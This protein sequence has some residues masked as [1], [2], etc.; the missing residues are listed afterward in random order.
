MELSSNL[1]NTFTRLINTLT[2][3]DKAFLIACS[4]KILFGENC[5][6]RVDS[7]WKYVLVNDKQV[8]IG[9]VKI[10]QYNE[11]ER[12]I[13]EI[14]HQNEVLKTKNTELK[15]AL[16]VNK[17]K[18][19]RKLGKL[20]EQ[21]NMIEKVMIN[22]SQMKKFGPDVSTEN[23]AMKN[24][25]WIDDNDE[26]IKELTKIYKLISSSKNIYEKYNQ[27]KLL[28]LYD[29]LYEQKFGKSDSDFSEFQKDMK[30]ALGI[31]RWSDAKILKKIEL[32]TKLFS[33]LPRGSWSICSIPFSYW[34]LIYD[35]YWN[36][37]IDCTKKSQAFPV[38]EITLVSDL[39]RL[40]ITGNEGEI[41][42]DESESEED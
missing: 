2:E 35:E 22:I 15:Q 29:N 41:E 5:Y 36:I 3:H 27:L 23:E 13:E 14:R 7:E 12:Q 38:D 9:F 42:V 25:K 21:K 6:Q 30:S 8:Y 4:D 24:V 17:K 39:S 1:K 40:N 32:F 37:I 11:L 33:I 16:E 19:K 18:K 20:S 26:R 31:E 34:N 10:D 28:S